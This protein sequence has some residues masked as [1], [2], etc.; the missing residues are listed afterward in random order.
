MP[1]FKSLTRGRCLRGL[2]VLSIISVFAA[3]S[4]SANTAKAEAPRSSEPQLNRTID[5]NFDPDTWK[6]TA[7]F[8]LPAME[9]PITFKVKD[10]ASYWFDHE[11]K[12]IEK[13]THSRSLGAGVGP[14]TIKMLIN[15]PNIE[16]AHTVTF[17][18]WPVGAK[19]MPFDSGGK[20]GEVSINLETPGLYAWQCVIHPY[21]LGA[22]VIDDPSTPGA[23]FGK[24][25]QWIDGEPIAT[26]ADE[27]L[28]V[29]HSFFIITEPANW[30]IY[31]ADKEM[32]WDPQYPKA[33]I[34][35]YNEDG[36][37]HLINN[38]HETLTKMHDEPKMLKPP[39]A[40][41]EPGVGTIYYGSQWEQSAGKTKP[42]SITVF[43][44]EN[45]Q[46]TN[47]WFG[48]SVNLNN[49]H[50]FWSDLQGEFLYST[51]WYA[52][53]MTTL[54]RKT[55]AVLRELVIGPSPS[56]I[57]TRSTNDNLVIPNNGGGRVSE[58][59]RGGTEVVA[60]YMTQ[61]RGE[62]PAFPH[63]HWV[64]GNGK[65]V[66]TPNSHETKAS[67]IDM[68]VPAMVKP[69][70]G[71]HPVAASTDN[72]SKRAYV[73]NLF[74]HTVTCASI[75]EPACPTPDGKIVP[76]YNIDLRQNYDKISGKSTGPFALAP[77]QL[78]VSPD[79][80]AM[81]T[82][83]TVTGN[84]VIIDPKTNKFVKTLPC[85]PGCHG[86]N[87]GAK[88]GGGYYAYITTKF[89]NKMI[90]VNA[91]PNNDG[92]LS[93]AAI[94]GEVLTS[95]NAAQMDDTPTGNFGQGGNGLFIYPIAYNG[96]VQKMPE[97]EKAKLT[98]RQREPLSKAL[99]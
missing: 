67:I 40:P 59:S 87:W 81:F 17:V 1:T 77:I 52:N 91:D 3:F 19:N 42:G 57:V 88:K 61:A 96:W 58:V 31:A 9:S 32:K 15:E 75:E 22:V 12:D 49:P 65:Y 95:G 70:T 86:G 27:V 7:E 94:V 11:N 85:G 73:A 13:V 26:S 63:G 29:V 74:S 53:N 34:M 71:H 45:W 68:S 66:V 18:T 69:E 24:Q 78:P 56:H 39:K 28:K 30:Q 90:V 62:K 2:A 10:D 48:P 98:C 76:T 41:T 99:C 72:A 20:T 5:P 8:P 84:I 60:T 23:D 46:M 4:A 6:P 16:E 93:D 43:D 79:D 83:G 36:S 21:M 44:A 82:V 51:N 50:N 97:A 54:D 47:K 64:T 38:L 35:T 55:G 33:P 89:M 14:T 92:D 37:P 80:N 25:L